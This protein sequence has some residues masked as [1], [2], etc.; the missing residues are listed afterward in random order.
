MANTDKTSSAFTLQVRLLF[1][2]NILFA[3]V[4]HFNMTK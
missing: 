1:N 4:K 2:Y 3:K